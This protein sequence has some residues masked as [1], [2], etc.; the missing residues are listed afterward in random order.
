MVQRVLQVCAQP[1]VLAAAVAR[2]MQQLRE[3]AGMAAHRVAV[4]V[5]AAREK[6]ITPQV[7]AVMAHVAKSGLWSTKRTHL[8]GRLALG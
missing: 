1:P 5:V 6:T 3:M 2:R 4:A 7:L 8:P